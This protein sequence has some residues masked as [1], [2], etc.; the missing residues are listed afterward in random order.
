MTSTRNARFVAVLMG[1]I[2]AG[3]CATAASADEPEE[4]AE[5]RVFSLSP[6]EKAKLEAEAYERERLGLSGLDEA[7]D[8]RIHG[9]ASIMVGTGGAMGVATSMV[10][11]VGE[12]ATVGAAFS[13]ERNTY[14]YDPYYGYGYGRY[15]YGYRGTYGASDYFGHLERVERIERYRGQ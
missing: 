9:E 4:T 10:A 5:G 15:P 7:G 13:Y 6:E 12:N 2:A 14:R 1:G 3:F 8:R 11:P